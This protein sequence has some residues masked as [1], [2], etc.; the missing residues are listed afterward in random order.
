M[1]TLPEAARLLGLA[2]ATLRSQIRFGRIKGR[3]VSR[4]W[5]FTAEEIE[6]YR[7]EQLGRFQAKSA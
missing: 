7:A 4:D 6:R 5:Y 3:K 2:P 1:H